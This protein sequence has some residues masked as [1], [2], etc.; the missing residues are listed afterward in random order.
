M[1]RIRASGLE[2]A[3]G[4]IEAQQ[5]TAIANRNSWLASPAANRCNCKRRWGCGGQRPC[6]KGRPTTGA[7]SLITAA[8][9]W[10]L[11]G[12]LPCISVTHFLLREG[13][14]RP[15]RSWARIRQLHGVVVRQGFVPQEVLAIHIIRCLI[16]L[17]RT[18]ACLRNGVGDG[19]SG[20]PCPAIADA[21][22][23]ANLCR[24]WAV[25][26][27]TCDLLAKLMPKVGHAQRIRSAIMRGP[28]C[29]LVA[30][31]AQPRD[32]A[33][34]PSNLYMPAMRCTVLRLKLKASDAC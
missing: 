22:A 7:E 14:R 2:D 4:L 21:P 29:T 8:C 11:L 13:L 3:V 33:S 9:L 31:S 6:T 1:K 19:G 30:W 34:R 15:R 25:A 17:R 27:E 28:H 18:L 16:A 26:Q 20:L 5:A 24:S 10:S 32:C 12:I 23:I